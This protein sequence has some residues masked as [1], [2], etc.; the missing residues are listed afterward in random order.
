MSGTAGLPSLPAGLPP[1]TDARPLAGG[2]VGQ[3]WLARLSDGTTVVVKRGPGDATLEAEGLAALRTAGA[4]TPAVLGV[5]D[6]VIV[7]EY[8]SEPGDPADLGRRLARV[9]ATTGPGFGWH[10][11]NLIGPLPQA[12]PW[13]DDWAGFLAEQR[14]APHLDALPGHLRV[15][16]ARAIDDGRLARRADHDVATSLVHGDLWA[17][18]ILH[19]RWLIDP[20]VHHADREVD[21]A[22]L[23]LFGAVPPTMQRGYDEV[24]PLDAGAEERRPLLQLYPLLVHVRL[25]GSAYLPS[26]ASRLDQLG[27]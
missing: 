21:L 17:G 2:D 24:W 25:F 4:E 16:I 1:P 9:H 20:A 10:R 23:E 13:H 12:N 22:M 26:V 6:T 27:W 15:R 11:D 8:V 3:A 19:E 14:L 5:E 18:N 7:L